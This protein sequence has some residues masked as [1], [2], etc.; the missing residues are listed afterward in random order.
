[1]SEEV[2]FGVAQTIEYGKHLE[3]A[4]DGK[5]AV[6]EKA[7]DHYA[8]DF[9]RFLDKIN[10]SPPKGDPEKWYAAVKKAAIAAAQA[11]ASYTEGWAMNNHPWINRTGDAERGLTGYTVIDGVKKAL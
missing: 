6:C 4:H 8:P 10:S 1:M 2:G 5:Y 3:T 7:V 11:M 9:S